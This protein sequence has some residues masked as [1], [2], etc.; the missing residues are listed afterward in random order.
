MFHLFKI[1]FFSLLVYLSLLGCEKKKS[2]QVKIDVK[3]DNAANAEVELVTINLLTLDNIALA[4]CKLDSAGKGQ[5]EF[6]LDLPVFA[7]V[8]QGD[9]YSALFISPG[10][11]QMIVA[12]SSKNGKDFKYS[13]SGASFNSYLQKVNLVSQKYAYND[14]RMFNALELSGFN[15]RRDSLERDLAGVLAGLEKDESANERG[16]QIMRMRNKLLVYSLTQNYV[17]SKYGYDLS[18]PDIPESLKS[19]VADLPQDSLALASNIYEYGLV[20]MSHLQSGI[21]WPAGDRMDSMKT[22]SPEL[23]LPSFAAEE[24]EMRHYIRPVEDHLQAANIN[25]WLR[26]DGLSKETNSLWAKFQKQ[27]RNPRYKE[28]IQKSYDQ[29]VSLAPGKPAP[30]FTGTTSDGKKISLS[31]LKGKLVYVDVWATWCGPCREEFP[32]SKKLMRQF[33]G[34]DK[35]AFLYVSTDENVD[36]WKKLLPDQSVPAGIH[37]NQKQEKQPDAIWDNYH[38]WGIPRYILIDANGNMLKTHAP[39]PSSEDILPLLKG[40]LKQS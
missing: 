7:F 4:T 36:T 23:D 6:P 37:I 12:D 15:D 2:D 30:D 21:M 40:Y 13:G 27:V 39:R 17:T 14:Y 38:L 9:I 16:L 33:E 28:T 34:N 24:I 26:M 3:L 5:F 19:I 29:W 11:E 8:K 31:S 20:L 18:N 10:D 22:T 1:S 25:Y 32:H 35:I